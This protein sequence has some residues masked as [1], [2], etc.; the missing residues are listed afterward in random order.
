M[1]AID[2]LGS[3]AHPGSGALL[4]LKA[5]ATSKTQYAVGGA[6][7]SQAIFPRLGFEQKPKLPMF[8][9]L[10]AP[11]HRLRSTRQGLFR[12]WAGTVKDVASDWRAHTAC[13]AGCRTALGTYVSRR[14][15]SR[16]PF[17][18]TIRRDRRGRRF[19]AIQPNRRRA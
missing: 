6:S 7:Q 1:L 4:M 14:S 5:F 13:A 18:V 9:K 10:L 12:K 15:S 17:D 3:A 8:Y 16:R 11:F 19:A 2:W